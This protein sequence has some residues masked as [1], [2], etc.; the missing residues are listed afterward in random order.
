MRKKPCSD[1]GAITLEETQPIFKA[2]KMFIRHLRCD[3]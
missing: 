3:K 2:F 1:R